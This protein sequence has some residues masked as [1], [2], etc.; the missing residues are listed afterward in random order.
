MSPAL[1]PHL[2]HSAQWPIYHT[3][4][5][6]RYFLIFC[7]QERAM[8]GT[9]LGPSCTHH[10][11]LPVCTAATLPQYNGATT[12]MKNLVEI[13]G[14]GGDGGTYTR[15]DGANYQTVGASTLKMATKKS[16]TNPFY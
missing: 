10:A 4:R 12:M 2:Y 9:Q 7:A 1:Y 11:H 13:F 5:G 6:H 15:L 3:V 14:V 8:Y 16:K